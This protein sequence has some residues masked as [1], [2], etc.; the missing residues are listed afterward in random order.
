VPFG[1]RA[2]LAV[3]ALGGGDVHDA[4]EHQRVG[5]REQRREALWRRA[6]VYITPSQVREPRVYASASEASAA[7]RARAQRRESPARAHG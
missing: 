1:R 3:R 4:A 2:D 5:A 7:G 6:M